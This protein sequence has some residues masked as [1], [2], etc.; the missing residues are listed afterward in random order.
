MHNAIFTTDAS[1]RLNSLGET[2]LIDLIGHWLQPCVPAYPIGI[3]DDC[4]ILAPTVPSS[5]PSSS[6]ALLT[7]DSLV[8]GRHFSADCPPEWVGAKLIKRCVS[9]I[10]ACGGTPAEALLAFF[11]P[12]ETSLSW[13]RRFCKGIATAASRWGVSVVGGDL[14]ETPGFLGATCSL[15]GWT[16]QPLL[17]RGTVAGAGLYL[18]GPVGG[19]LAGHHLHFTPRLAEGQFLASL[20]GPITCIDLTDGL[21][22]DAPEL[23][24]PDNAWALDL[25][26]LPISG[27]ARRLPGDPLIRALT[28]GEDYELLFTLPSSI[29]SEA[30]AGWTQAFGA[31]PSRIG[32][33][34]TRPKAHPQACLL[35]ASTLAP[36]PLLNGY[37]HFQRT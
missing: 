29:E 20:P 27:A 3:G 15:H 7:N 11:L 6:R 5:V 21:I 1:H 9:D 24:P 37:E 23:L 14:T 22:K 26:A 10:A 16:R 31:P 30:I 18:S 2:I 36:L 33:L 34:V 4:A 12:A 32:Q 8:L 35:D 28:D 19:S 17:R 13:L 25:Q